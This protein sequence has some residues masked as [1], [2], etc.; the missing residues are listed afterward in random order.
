PGTALLHLYAKNKTDIQPTYNALKR[1]AKDYDVYLASNMPAR[2]H[3]SKKDD[4][5]DR[6]GD[7]IL[8]PHA[9]KVFNIGKGHV[10]VGEHGFDPAIPEMRATFYAWGP[11]FQKNKTIDGFENIHVYPIMARILGLEIT[12]AIDG[13]I[14]VLKSILAK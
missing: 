12:D 2:W 8:V 14:K 1:E 3:Y 9:P 10:P 5:F 7:I 11:A 4:R 6:I 13:K